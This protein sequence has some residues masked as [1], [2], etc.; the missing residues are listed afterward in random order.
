MSALGHKRTFLEVCIM[1]AL[2]PKADIGTQPCN[3]RA[4]RAKSPSLT[5]YCSFERVST[6]V[7]LYFREM[8]FCR[9]ETAAPKRPVT[10]NRSS[11]ETKALHENPEIRRYLHDTRKSPFVWD[12]VV[13]PGRLEFN[14][15]VIVK[16]WAKLGPAILPTSDRT[17]SKL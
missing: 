4:N 11:A 1:S 8:R 6:T 3:V 17:V 12:C 2:P 14:Q 15:A 10:A 7:G 9:A 5:S 13:G 16:R